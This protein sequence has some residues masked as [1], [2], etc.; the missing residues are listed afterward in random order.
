MKQKPELDYES[1]QIQEG[2][3]KEDRKFSGKGNNMQDPLPPPPPNLHASLLSTPHRTERG[4]A[5]RLCGVPGLLHNHLDAGSGISSMCQ[6]KQAPA[7][8]SFA[9]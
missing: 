1:S 7:Q 3:R 4:R 6:D 2:E 8:A 9:R 5:V